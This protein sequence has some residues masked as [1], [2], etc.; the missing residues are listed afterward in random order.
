MNL[1]EGTRSYLCRLEQNAKGKWRI[2]NQMYAPAELPRGQP[3]QEIAEE[4]FSNGIIEG[5]RYFER[6]GRLPER[7][8]ILRIN[9]KTIVHL[10]NAPLDKDSMAAF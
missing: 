5:K 8:S 7:I 4:M 10:D 1:E 6:T 3:S 2:G 9:E